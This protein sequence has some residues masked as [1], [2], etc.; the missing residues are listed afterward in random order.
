[1]IVTNEKS[2]AQ[3]AKHL[4]TTAKVEHPYLYFHDQ[5]GFNFRL[6]NLNAS[7]GLSQMTQLPRFLDTK[8]KIAK[9]YHKAAKALGLTPLFEPTH[10]RSNYWLNAVIL[11]DHDELIECL[12]HTN[13]RGIVTRPF[14]NLM[15][16]LP[17]Y[18]NCVRGDVR[19]AR[20]LCERVLCLPSSVI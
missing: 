11:K 5:I 3:L 16:D 17:M 19:V 1:M 7:L 4:T 8:R 12:E 15:T 6:P 14:W 10:A 20:E 13:Q 9:A 18:Q 2:L